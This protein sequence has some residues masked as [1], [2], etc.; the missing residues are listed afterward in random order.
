MLWTTTMALMSFV[1]G[2]H[3]RRALVHRVDVQRWWCH[4]KHPVRLHS[5]EG[6]RDGLNLDLLR[7]ACSNL[8]GVGGGLVVIR[9][10]SSEV[11]ESWE[12]VRGHQGGGARVKFD[13][14]RTGMQWV[15]GVVGSYLTSSSENS[16]L[17]LCRG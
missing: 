12:V 14:R 10:A 7:L 4:S 9:G 16:T 6:K 5:T 17:G 11:V 3:R 2:V 8:A 13:L 1:G 15:S